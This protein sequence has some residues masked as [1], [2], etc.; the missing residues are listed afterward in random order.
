MDDDYI[1]EIVDAFAQK[2][3]GMMLL[4]TGNGSFDIG[5]GL[6]EGDWLVLNDPRGRVLVYSIKN[7]D[8]RHRFFGGYAAINPR[9]NQIA[10]ENIA[11]EVA[12]FNL[13]TGNR[14]ANF[15]I[16]G[17]AAFVRFNLEGNKLLILSDAQ[18]VY[19]FDLNRIAAQTSKETK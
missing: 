9:K 18:T 16:N 6:S 1:V 10:V 17:S 19:A 8:L 7:G 2:T 5:K 3:A 4:D 11:G 13:D 15:V 14:E 12:L